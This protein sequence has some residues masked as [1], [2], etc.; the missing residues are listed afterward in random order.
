MRNSKQIVDSI[1]SRDSNFWIHEGNRQSLR[2][3]HKAAQR[4]PAYKDFLKKEAIKP[5]HIKTWDDFQNV[6]PVNKKDYLMKYPIE[7]LCWDGKLNN[8]LVYTA[9]SGSTGEPLYFLRTEQLDY[10]YSLIIKVLLDNK[11]QSHR[12]S[13]LVINAF[14]M[15]VWIGG[16]ITYKAFEIAS[17]KWGYSLSIITPGINMP[18][19]LSAL[20]KLSPKYKRTI[21]VGYPPFVKDIL[22]T[23]VREKIDLKKLHTRF[24]FAAESFDENFRQYIYK[25]AGVQNILTDTM[26]VYGSAELGAMASETPFTIL[27]RKEA[28]KKKSLYRKLL[29]QAHRIPT[30]A[31]YCPYF[32]NFEAVNGEL[33][34]TGD[35][36]IPFVRYAI[37]DQGGAM[38]FSK[39]INI[40]KENGVDISRNISSA[41]IKNT[42]TQLP[43]VYVYERKDFVISFYGLQMY[44]EHIREAL[45]S[46]SLE[47]LIT[48]KFTIETKYDNKQDQFLELMIE[49]KP[50][51][52]ISMVEKNKILEKVMTVLKVKNSEFNE[53]HKYLG[54]RAVPRLVFFGYQDPKHF[55]QGVKQKWVIK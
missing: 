24:L 55:T 15:G 51:V 29:N 39:A 4:V 46:S 34:I 22:D 33:Y 36:A 16:L 17:R 44:P 12:E 48:G 5:A 35:N 26:N 20:K 45:L 3:F 13:T 8:A 21:L 38:P 11:K 47:K 30:V 43:I 6:P 18:Q 28:I 25:I 41:K 10:Q 42:L 49:L 9:T 31:Q 1:K 40:C 53:L 7:D 54:N 23:A 27:L 50:G 37:G 2:L 14:S 52:L 19:I 32:I